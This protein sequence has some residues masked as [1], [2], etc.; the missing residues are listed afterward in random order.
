[1]LQTALPLL[2]A[3]KV[4]AIEWAFDSL[5]KHR[6]IPD[7]FLELL[8][9]FGDEGRL[10][11]HGVYFS[12][13]KGSWTQEQANWLKLLR[14]VVSH[15]KFD[16]ISEHFGFMTGEDFHK[17]APLHIPLNKATLAI[18]KDRLSRIQDACQLPVG[19][20]NL[21][22]AYCLQDVQSQVEFLNQLLFDIN[23]FLILD[24][25]NLYCQMH[26][27][28]LAADQILSAYDL[29]RVREIHISGGSWEPNPINKDKQIRRDTHDDAVPALVFTL[30]ENFI[31]KCPNL[32][33]VVLEQLGNGLQTQSAQAQFHT[34]F[35][36]MDKIVKAFNHTKSLENSN[37]F[38]P[39]QN[40][41]KDII[42]E[43]PN[44]QSQQNLLSQIL[45]EA[46]DYQDAA[47]QLNNSILSN[48]DWKV[49]EWSPAMLGT[50]LE[51]A[52]KWK[53]GF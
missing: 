4:E 39:L 52:Q 44:L 10:I 31:P 23:G 1:M 50:A 46:N 42:F 29:D 33:F 53:R 5:Y 13:F 41:V 18:G 16:H 30:L 22:F 3:E 15:F 6:N 27:F 2:Q 49:E 14:K 9:A 25:H 43:D 37:D 34:D 17:G 40:I 20:E 36:K 7:W 8:K 12:L 47:H 32:K 51:I 38:L 35:L 48:S 21:A 28:D 24:I 45:E 26:N 11:G 19:L